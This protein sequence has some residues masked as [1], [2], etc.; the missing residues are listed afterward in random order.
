MS[1]EDANEI[2]NGRTTHE[3]PQGNQHPR[4]VEA[5]HIEQTEN[6]EDCVSILTAPDVNQGGKHGLREERDAPEHVRR[7]RLD[8]AHQEHCPYEVTGT[9]FKT[10]H[11]ELLSISYK[12]E[13]GHDKREAE[14]AEEDEV[15][16]KAPQLEASKDSTEVKEEQRG[17]QELQLHPNGGAERGS[18]VAAC[19][20]WERAVPFL[21][22]G[23]LRPRR[24]CESVCVDSGFQGARGE[25]R[26]AER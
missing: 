23:H 10:A 11:L 25:R 3:Y 6:R 15:C 13:H 19:D 18:H 14:G 4:P 7:G 20:R 5:L 21:G 12:E 22:R 8:H 2:I 16:E 24:V 9:S 17:R 26:G 1:R